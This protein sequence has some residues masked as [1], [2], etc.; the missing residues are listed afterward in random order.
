LLFA[1]FQSGVK[2]YTKAVLR[3]VE[4]SRGVGAWVRMLGLKFLKFMIDFNAVLRLFL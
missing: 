3:A 1:R 2:F 4:F